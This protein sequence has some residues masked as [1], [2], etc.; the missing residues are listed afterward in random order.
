MI[1]TIDIRVNAAHPN[2]ALAEVCGFVGSPSSVR[3]ANVPE[4]IGNWSLTSVRL[5]VSYPDNV[6]T[7][8]S[9]VRVNGVWTGTIPAPE[10]AGSVVGGFKVLAD[11]TDENGEPVTGYVLG[12]GDVRV[13]NRDN[14][15]GDTAYPLHLHDETP[16][17]PK[18]ADVQKMDE[19]WK[20]FNG[21]GWE[22]FGGLDYKAGEGLALSGDTFSLSAS[23]PSRTSEL[24]NDSGYITKDSVPLVTKL[25]SLS[26]DVD[27]PSST[28]KYY[29]GNGKVWKYKFDDEWTLSGRWIY[30]KSLNKP[31][32]WWRNFSAS[33]LCCDVERGVWEYKPDSSYEPTVQISASVSADVL[34]FPIKNRVDR[35][36]HTKQNSRWEQQGNIVDSSSNSVAG[37]TDGDTITVRSGRLCA[38]EMSVPRMRMIQIWGSEAELPYGMPEYLYDAFEFWYIQGPSGSVVKTFS[39][40][41]SQGKAVYTNDQGVEVGRFY[42]VNQ[43]ETS[44]TEYGGRLTLRV[45]DP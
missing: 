35:F 24:E 44:T 5:F 8:R 37:I 43:F 19:R 14:T 33:Y 18:K 28:S 22:T 39:H 17:E 41:T 2:L 36:V 16:D 20:I 32:R 45:L 7:E 38:N 3:I 42:W 9:C 26:S 29:E 23:I 25:Y 10:R 11:G 31:P 40:Y 30:M 6:E 12:V 21:E 27:C 34:E 1:G 4:R 15:E 13:L